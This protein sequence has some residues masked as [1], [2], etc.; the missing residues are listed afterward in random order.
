M[1]GTRAARAA[2]RV[3]QAGARQPARGDTDSPAGAAA[4]AI[5]A[6]CCAVSAFCDYNAANGKRTAHYQFYL[7]A[8]RAAG[9][10][11]GTAAAAAYIIRG[12]H[13]TIDYAALRAAMPAPAGP[14]VPAP[15]PAIH[16]RTGPAPTP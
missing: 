16:S 5:R 4:A 3:Q 1:C 8:A 7:A 11:A 6:A 15:A 2:R 10:A 12:F 13:G 9:H 14:A